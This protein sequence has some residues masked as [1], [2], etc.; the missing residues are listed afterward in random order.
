MGLLCVSQLFSL[1]QHGDSL[2]ARHPSCSANTIV[3]ITRAA[4]ER[5]IDPNG[6]QAPPSSS[7]DPEDWFV[8]G[9][10]LEARESQLVVSFEEADMWPINEDDV[11]Q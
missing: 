1:L 5:D 3:R 10:V 2:I 4:P 7:T 8:Q 9:T 6:P 11:F